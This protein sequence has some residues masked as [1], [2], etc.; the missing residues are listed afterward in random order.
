MTVLALDV[1]G[2]TIRGSV[3]DAAGT[4]VAEHVVPTGDRDPGLGELH[5]VATRLRDA[6]PD[7]GAPLRAV[8]VGMP[9]Y[10][11][12]D[13]R[14]T[15]HEVLD[16]TE[17]PRSL[18]ADVAPIVAVDSDVRCSARA[19]L[20]AGRPCDNLVVVSVGTGVSH[21]VIQAGRVIVGARGEAIGLGQLPVG[22]P[23]AGRRLSVEDVASGAGIARRYLER[24]QRRPDDGAREVV[25]LAEE[26][27]ADALVLLH[28]AGHALAHA[29]W[30]VV[31]I[32]DPDRIV[33]TG[34]LGSAAGPLHSSLYDSYEALV[35]NRPGAASIEIS[36]FGDRAGLV[37]AEILARQALEQEERR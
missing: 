16:W 3:R 4:T 35:Q 33:L 7:L 6:A 10:V 28:E 25:R 14:L 36:H 31:Q 15:S 1:G 18:L 34:G 9:E 27:D 11:D 8:G 2:S 5:R 21:A 32:L 17:Q 29:I 20:T 23:R 13:G 30:A 19:E 12:P 24:T 37:G 22:E 26:G